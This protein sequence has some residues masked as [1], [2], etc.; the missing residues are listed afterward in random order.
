[1]CTRH[2][3][4]LTIIDQV[5]DFLNSLPGG[6]YGDLIP[7]FNVA[8]THKVPV[9]RRAEDG[10][11]VTEAS[12]WNMRTPWHKSLKDGKYTLHN[13][14][15]YD[16]V[17]GKTAVQ[18]PAWKHPWSRGQFCVIPMDAAIE[19]IGPKGKKM[20]VKISAKDGSSLLVAGLYNPWTDPE[21]GKRYQ[22]HTLITTEPSDEFGIIHD[23]MPALLTPDAARA[24]L[25]P[26]QTD[27]DAK[28]E[29][30][31]GAHDIP[32]DFAIVDKAINASWGKNYKNGPEFLRTTDRRTPLEYLRENAI[33]PAH[34]K[35]H[36]A[37]KLSEERT[38]RIL[39]LVNK[40]PKTGQGELF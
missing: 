26:S 39:D 24:F 32:L 20:P 6:G 22:T 13:A 4:S 9:V 11:N 34:W 7:N 5:N 21:D 31:D 3:Q 12:I 30:I 15:L 33:E 18:K 10:V 16:R 37:S 2:V 14:M 23:R 17:S 19:F 1:M 35:W 40:T 27:F 36:S 8:I 38:N 25:D 29:L 28:K